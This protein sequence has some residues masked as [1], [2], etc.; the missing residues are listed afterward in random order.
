MHIVFATSQF[1]YRDKT[2]GGL[3]AYLVKIA[4]LMKARGHSVSVVTL[5]DE[6]V[7]LNENG[8]AIYT[9]KERVLPFFLILDFLTL[10]IFHKAILLISKSWEIDRNLKKLHKNNKIDFI[11]YGSTYG[12]SFFVR[13][14][15][16][17]C[18]RN[19][20]LLYQCN[21]ANKNNTYFDWQR[22]WVQ[23]EALKRC[24][25]HFAPSSTT[26]DL[27]KKDLNIN[28]AL[29]KTP[30]LA[31]VEGV[32]NT[33][34]LDKIRSKGGIKYLLFFGSLGELKGI[35]FIGEILN[36]F[37][38]RNPDFHFVFAGNELT[39]NNMPAIS[40]LKEKAGDEIAKCHFTGLIKK[41]EVYPLIEN[42]YASVLPSL[43]D[44]SPNS[45]MEAMAFGKVILS[46]M[47]GSLRELVEHNKNGF[48]VDVANPEAFLY[49]L[50]E[51]CNLDM[52]RLHEMEQYALLKAREHDPDHIADQHVAFYKDVLSKWK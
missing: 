25:F 30:N 22:E 10:L 38:K 18:C 15:I 12:I 35:Q 52:K 48:N 36:E 47:D 46:S 4:G 43:V 20:G 21:R 27:I 34:Q 5:S 1:N 40:Y 16:P 50:D 44:N 24:K 2:Y 19:S 49:A 17:H 41:E 23:I 32:L 6:T 9:I 37:F 28:S 39:V 51:L 13:R 42:C 7:Q 8:V 45:A 3:A 31:K 14:E 29:I 26:N 33:T 11:Q